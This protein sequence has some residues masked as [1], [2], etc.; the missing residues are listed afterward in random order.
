MVLITFGIVSLSCYVYHVNTLDWLCVIGL[1]VVVILSFD[2][3]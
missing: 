3:L 1:I 2:G